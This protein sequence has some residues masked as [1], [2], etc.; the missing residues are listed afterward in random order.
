M[1]SCCCWGSEVVEVEQEWMGLYE[2]KDV[3]FNLVVFMDRLDRT[4][5][6]ERMEEWRWLYG[7]GR[8]PRTYSDLRLKA[9]VWY[10]MPHKKSSSKR[11]LE[12]FRVLHNEGSLDTDER[13]YLL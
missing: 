6:Y 10:D 2:S 12:F 13:T 1:F 3:N 4:T 11:A 5:P 7:T 8:V 9:I